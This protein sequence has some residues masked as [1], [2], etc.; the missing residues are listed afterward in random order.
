[1]LSRRDTF[2]ATPK[3]VAQIASYS[4]LKWWASLDCPSW[5]TVEP[6]LNFGERIRDGAIQL[7]NLYRIRTY[8]RVSAPFASF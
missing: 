7:E 2:Y 3:L 5:K 6:T 4:S 1:M 8:K